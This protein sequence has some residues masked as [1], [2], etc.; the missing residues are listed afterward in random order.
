MASFVHQLNISRSFYGYCATLD[1]KDK[2]DDNIVKEDAITEHET[3]YSF[4]LTI[5][6]AEELYKTNSTIEE[7]EIDDDDLNDCNLND[8][9]K[10]HL[11]I[12]IAI[13]NALRLNCGWNIPKVLNY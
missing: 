12:F 11:C 13:L 4:L 1:I 6:P 7:E 10:R 9:D 8:A 5:L 3:L 2:N